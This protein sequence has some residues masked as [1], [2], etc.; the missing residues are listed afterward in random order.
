MPQ[1]TDALRAAFGIPADHEPIGAIA[2]GHD[3]STDQEKLAARRKP[4]TEMVRY[5]RW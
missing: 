5:G 2:I 3:A 1:E 4:L